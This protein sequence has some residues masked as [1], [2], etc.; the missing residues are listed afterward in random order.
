MWFH[1]SKWSSGLL[2]NHKHYPLLRQ[3][4]L[5]A[6]WTYQM[7]CRVEGHSRIALSLTINRWFNAPN[8][9]TQLKI[10]TTVFFNLKW[11]PNKR[12]QDSSEGTSSAQVNLLSSHRLAKPMFNNNN[13]NSTSIKQPYLLPRRTPKK[14]TLWSRMCNVSSLNFPRP[15]PPIPPMN[16]CTRA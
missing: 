11:R 15:S 6:S 16:P 7:S 4:C 9:L 14:F 3:G 5:R 2:T 12:N 13:R 10:L 8:R 1:S